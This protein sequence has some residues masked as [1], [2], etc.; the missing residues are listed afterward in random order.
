MTTIVLCPSM[1][2]TWTRH[3]GPHE[4]TGYM[5]Y[6]GVRSVHIN[7]PWFPDVTFVVSRED[8]PAAFV[9]IVTDVIDV[10]LRE[11]I[12]RRM[13]LDVLSQLIE[14]VKGAHAKAFGCGQRDVRAKLRELIQP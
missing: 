10:Q 4:A 7:V 9:T 13:S 8:L 1:G 6:L 3:F 12:V 11:V 5:I 14:A 2:G